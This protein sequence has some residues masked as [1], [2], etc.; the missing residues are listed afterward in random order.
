MPACFSSPGAVLLTGTTKS[1][2]TCVPWKWQRSG[3]LSPPCG[4]LVLRQSCEPQSRSRV[5]PR[6]PLGTKGV[7]ESESRAVPGCCCQGQ[8]QARAPLLPV[9]LPPEPALHMHGRKREFRCPVSTP[10]PPHPHFRSKITATLQAP[11]PV[12][13][14]ERAVCAPSSVP[15]SDSEPSCLLL[16]SL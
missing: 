4:Q 14:G 16:G 11:Q 1:S 7:R 12:G 15:F 5:A 10:P 3:T 9:L 6:S 8:S 2:G 13:E